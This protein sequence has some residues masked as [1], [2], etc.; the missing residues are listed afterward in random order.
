M[1]N[2]VY[3]VLCGKD[4]TISGEAYDSWDKAVNFVKNR[5]NKPTPISS[6][7]WEW[8]ASDGYEYEIKVLNLK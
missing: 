4:K 6:S 2:Y 7:A 3:V 1:Y 5:A 8:M